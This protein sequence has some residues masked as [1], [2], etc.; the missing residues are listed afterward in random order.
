MTAKNASLFVILFGLLALLS[1]PAMA[2]EIQIG[3]SS[4]T[5]AIS[6]NFD[7]TELV[8]FGTIEGADPER[9]AKGAYDVAV[10]LLGPLEPVV[11]RR[12]EHQFG[13]WANG[14]S[15]R[16]ENVPSSYSV[17]TTRALNLI[18]TEDEAKVLQIGLNNISMKP[19]VEN[20]TSPDV[21]IFSES[22]KR[23]KTT[24]DLYVE[25]I[26]GVDFISSTLFRARVP[27]PA[28]VPIGMHRARAFLFADG[29]VI[30]AKSVTLQVRKIGFEQ[31]TYSMA[32][33]N[34]FLYGII[35]VLVAI[36]TGWL[37]NV[38]FQKD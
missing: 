27:V 14:K 33:Q 9:L 13:I 20:E 30:N 17:A 2:Q 4:D 15:M 25:K 29:K 11:V 38:I 34:G 8:V 16:F 22:L 12:K 18:A 35:A 10:V 1:R 5:V 32:H 28:N 31:F 23:I 26:G 7:G 19:L 24:N 37:A 36:G 6:S 3:L 21:A